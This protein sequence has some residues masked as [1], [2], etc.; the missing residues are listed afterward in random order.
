MKLFIVKVQRPLSANVA[1]PPALVYSED[2]SLEEY[3]PF[4]DSLR[5]MM[6]DDLKQYHWAYKAGGK[7][8]LAGR[9]PDQRW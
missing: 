1:N 8:Y 2:H 3:F 4:D 9:A 6:G 7:L 5:E